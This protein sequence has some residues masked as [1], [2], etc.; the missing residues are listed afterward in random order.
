VAADVVGPAAQGIAQGNL[1]AIL[2]MIRAGLGYANMHTPLHPGGEIRGQ[3][4]VVG[5]S[6]RD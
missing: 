1:A 2:Q 4:R 3:I 6:D 5:G